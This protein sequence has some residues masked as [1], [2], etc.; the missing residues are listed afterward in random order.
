MYCPG[1]N[2][3]VGRSRGYFNRSDT[4]AER[5][6]DYEYSNEHR[7]PLGCPAMR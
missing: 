4:G 1:T 7:L 2:V 5:L 6:F 3:D